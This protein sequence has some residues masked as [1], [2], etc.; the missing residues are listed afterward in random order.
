[1]VVAL[2][3]T[4]GPPTPER[5]GEALA[6]LHELGVEVRVM[7]SCTAVD[8]RATYLAGSDRLRADDFTRAWCDPEVSAIVCARGGYGTVRM[9]DLLDVDRLA[10][11][12]A[13]PVLGSSDVTA[14]LEFLDERLGVPSWFTPMPA[15]IDLLGDPV[16]RQSFADA[17]LR[18]EAP[19][20]LEG[21]RCLVPGRASGRLV[22]GNLSLLAMTLAARTRPPFDHT[23]TIAIV[24]DVG[25]DTYKYDGYLTMLRRA[26]WFDGVRGVAIGSWARSDATAA[27]DLLRA[28]LAELGVPMVADLPFGHGPGA[29]ALRIG[30]EATLDADA[31]ILRMVDGAN[32]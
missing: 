12:P 15:T 11:H 26:G 32:W 24:E 10:S 4:A 23:D 19:V 7:A 16:A 27:V 14:L 28:D 6:L 29:G 25:E 21:G 2:L 18:P 22:G 5:L 3:S 13:K 20:V 31:G 8:D 30:G 17:L 1:M 9:L